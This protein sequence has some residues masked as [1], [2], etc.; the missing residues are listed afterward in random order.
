MNAFLYLEA[1]TAVN[2]ASVYLYLQLI[3]V[4]TLLL[5]LVQREITYNVQEDF[6]RTLWRVSLVGIVPLL[7]AFLLILLWHL[8]RAG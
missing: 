2:Q 8:D 6:A 4:F 7:I 1:Q 3:A 5:L